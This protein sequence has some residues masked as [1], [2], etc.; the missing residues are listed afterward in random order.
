MYKRKNSFNSRGKRFNG[1]SGGFRSRSNFR[2]SSSRRPQAEKIDISRY[3][4]KSIP[5]NPLGEYKAKNTFRDFNFSPSLQANLDKKNFANPTPI[6]DQAI[7]PILEK[8]DLIG[9]ANTGTG[10]TAVFLLP[11]IDKVYKNKKEKVLIIAPTREL[12]IQIE[13][14]FRSFSGGMKIYSAICVGGAPINRQIFNLR[15]N[16]PNFVIGTPGR[17]KDL[18]KRK[19]LNFNSFQNIVLDEVDRMLDMGF[20]NDITEILKD[21][22]KDRQTLFFSATLPEKIRTLTKQFLNNPITVEV[23]SGETAVNVLQDIIRI[24][25][26]SEKFDKLKNL[27][28]QPEFKKVL[29]FTKTKRE[30]E[31]LS[32]DLS[33]DGYKSTSIHG[34]KRQS[35]RQKSLTAFRSDQYKILVATDVAA[36]GL[37]IN[38]ISHVINYTAPQTYDDYIHRIGRTGR[39]SKLGQA[40]TFID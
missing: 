12:A 40:L 38:D 26:K 24:R 39:A 20:I 5:V 37:D 3:I 10:K 27:L 2:R 36:R 9:L 7:R 35:Q 1:K 15:N 28:G 8:H 22:P 17:L 25:N 19:L 6:Q 32:I 30:V 31:K 11:L 34:D 29:I 18:S 16:S 23:K 21:L 14:E 33:R 4:Q 13:K